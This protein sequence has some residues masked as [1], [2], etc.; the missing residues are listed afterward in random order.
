[1]FFQQ[2]DR[3]ESF[4]K[5]EKSISQF[6]AGYCATPYVYVQNES[7]CKSLFYLSPP[8]IEFSVWTIP[9]SINTLQL[10][11]SASL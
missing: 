11:W 3:G 6:K 4:R 1:M 7:L 10:L 5:G 9:D 2:K 8:L